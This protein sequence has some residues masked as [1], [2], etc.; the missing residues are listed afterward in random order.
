MPKGSVSVEDAERIYRRLCVTDKGF[1]RR[2]GLAQRAHAE[3]VRGCEEET[4]ALYDRYP[5][6]RYYLTPHGYPF[7]LSSVRPGGPGGV[8]KLYGVIAFREGE[9]QQ[10]RETMLF[11]VDKWSNSDCQKILKL[12]DESKRECCWGYMPVARLYESAE[13][14]LHTDCRRCLFGPH[15]V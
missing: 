8:A 4:L 13:C 12:D 9:M 2:L 11:P 6:W 3:I 14:R 10:I 15:G 7:R 1:S 5:L